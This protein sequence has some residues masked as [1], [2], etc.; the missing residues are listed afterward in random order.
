MYYMCSVL[1]NSPFTAKS[2][3]K[4]GDSYK[5]I[6]KLRDLLCCDSFCS[7]NLIHQAQK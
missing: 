6:I 7:Q 1:I 5:H 4:N 3:V 2:V